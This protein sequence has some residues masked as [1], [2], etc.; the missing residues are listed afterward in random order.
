MGAYLLPAFFLLLLLHDVDGRL[1]E[2]DMNVPQIVEYYGYPI[3]IFEATT[4]DGYVLTLHRIPFEV[5]GKGASRTEKKPVVFLQ[6]GLIASSADWVTNLPNQSAG[7]VMADAGNCRGNVYSRKHVNETVRNY[8][9]FT[10]DEMANYDLPAMIDTVLK[11]TEQESLYY[12]TRKE[13]RSCSRDC[14]SQTASKRRRVFQ[15][16]RIKKFFALAP[17]ATV[18]YVQGLL[19]WLGDRFDG[20]LEASGCGR[21]A[22][23]EKLFYWFGA[24][25]FLGHN[26]ITDLFS[27]VICG[28]HFMNPV[29]RNVMF[30]I[31]GPETG[32]WND[33][34]L[35]VYMAHTPA[36]TSTVNI[37]HWIQVHLAKKLQKYDYGSTAANREHYGQDTPPVYNLSK[38]TTPTYLYFSPADWLATSR[39]VEES[40]IGVVDKR[41][42]KRIKPMPEFNHFDFIWSLNAK[43]KIYD[44]IIKAIR[45]SFLLEQ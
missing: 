16:H 21:G 22:R 26:W 14:P 4:K 24:H 10:W 35:L 5:K 15:S 31:G 29:C 33:S 9:S 28:A 13:R 30:Q 11:I 39:D 27:A 36:G 43:E 42:L 12:G 17:V 2:V 44:E 19:S 40:I 6:H 3:Q 41:Y 34:R 45:S 1:P 25:E 20:Q 38:I 37:V 7:F 23:E 18:T 32:N 8:W